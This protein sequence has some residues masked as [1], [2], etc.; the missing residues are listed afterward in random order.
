[1]DNDQRYVYF[2]DN[3]AFEET[4]RVGFRRRVINGEN[5]QL[6]FWRIADQATGSLI[7]RHDDAEIVAE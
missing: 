3:E 2:L 1:M 7:H 5:L 4:D 6:C